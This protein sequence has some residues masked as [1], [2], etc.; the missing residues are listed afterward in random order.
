[1]IDQFAT[2][3]DLVRPDD[4]ASP[5]L[6]ASNEPE[7]EIWFSAED[8]DPAEAIVLPFGG[9]GVGVV[10]LG[11]GGSHKYGGVRWGRWHPE[12]HGGGVEESV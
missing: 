2:W 5:S 6:L 4:F 8:E 12:R 9:S 10:Y 1:M 3:G 11:G 7:G